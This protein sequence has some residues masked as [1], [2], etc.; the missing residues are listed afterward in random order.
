MIKVRIIKSI[1][2]E[3]ALLETRRTRDWIEQQAKKKGRLRRNYK[4]TMMAFYNAGVQNIPDL[5]V[6]EPENP[7]DENLIKAIE[8]YYSGKF[9]ELLK[10]IG[11][12]QLSDFDKQ[13]YRFIDTMNNLADY[14][15]YEDEKAAQ[16]KSG[17]DYE[18][19][20]KTP[21]GAIKIAQIGDWELLDAHTGEVS[22]R[23]VV[24]T[25]WC[26][27]TPS[28]Y[29]QYI[30]KDLKLYY[31]FN[32]KMEYPN[33]KLSIGI[34]NGDFK[35]GGHGGFSVNARND[36]IKS[37]DQATSILGKDADKILNT[38][39]TYYKKDMQS[40]G[41]SASG[42]DDTLYIRSYP[43]FLRKARSL[44][45]S[46]QR[47]QFYDNLITFLRDHV[48]NT[49][50]F[51][52]SLLPI[53]AYILEDKEMR[54]T[55]FLQDEKENI[56]SEIGIYLSF[57]RF[58]NRASKKVPKYFDLIYDTMIKELVDKKGNVD[59]YRVFKTLHGI[60][61][62]PE[63][64][65]L[66]LHK[67]KAIEDLTDKKQKI[68]DYLSMGIDDETLNDLAQTTL[69]GINSKLKTIEDIVKIKE[70]T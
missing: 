7:Y 36:G 32:D 24:G 26:T 20:E 53:F 57:P 55:K 61:N 59:D 38:L 35:W 47:I 25:T 6:M 17:E 22:E 45:D 28:V 63:N 42:L 14:D 16:K 2:E 5:K 39:Q 37:Y 60:K 46:S 18:S 54:N 11:I 52:P 64:D 12:T 48:R 3:A 8:L 51:A 27:A 1:N 29:D 19:A 13:G 68:M 4:E 15:R 44:K 21:D 65:K 9:K 70:L 33:N 69:D 66:E 62:L 31:L 23:C 41:K 49:V 43:N 56:K 34:K 40:R 67:N 58:L 30:Q 50:R 10:S